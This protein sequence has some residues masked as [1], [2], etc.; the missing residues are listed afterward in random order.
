MKRCQDQQTKTAKKDNWIHSINNIRLIVA[1]TEVPNEANDVTVTAALLYELLST[2]RDILATA[3][4]QINNCNSH[5]HDIVFHKCISVS[6]C[7][8]LGIRSAF[9]VLY[10]LTNNV[11]AAKIYNN[12]KT[13]S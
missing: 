13:L 7:L 5:D 4:M 1:K 8:N 9:L 10:S 6:F 11:E 3:C 12:N 2:S